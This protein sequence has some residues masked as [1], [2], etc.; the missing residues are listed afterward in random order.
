MK[1]KIARKRVAIFGCHD[2]SI[3]SQRD[4]RYY[5]PF[6]SDRRDKET[7]E[8]IKRLDNTPYQKLR[9]QFIDATIEFSPEIMLQLPHTE[10]A[11]AAKWTKLD[12]WLQKKN[13]DKRLQHFAT[14]LKKK[15]K[16][17]KH[18]SP[19]GT[20]RGDVMNF[21]NGKLIN[22]TKNNKPRKQ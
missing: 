12:E 14:G 17:Q 18:Y 7:S 13:K 8:K 16:E 10:G 1:Q 21:D 9:C 15:P 20:Q 22:A 2:L 19:S 11:W 3:F 5:S 6:T 4:K